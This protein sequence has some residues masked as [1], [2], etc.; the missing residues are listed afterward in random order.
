MDSSTATAWLLPLHDAA[1]LF[2]S[3]YSTR[4]R[5]GALR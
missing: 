3:S 4:S 2:M 5:M 1:Q